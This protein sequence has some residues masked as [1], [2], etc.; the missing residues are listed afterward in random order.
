MQIFY[1]MMIALLAIFKIADAYTD[2][3]PNYFR[4]VITPLVT[5]YKNTPQKQIDWPAYEHLVQY[6]SSQHP[7]A[8]IA[9]S[10]VG[11]WDNISLGEK[12]KL[13]QTTVD[14]VQGSIPIYV[15]L[16]GRYDIKQIISLV[17]F[18]D[19]LDVSGYVITIP[20][21]VKTE[22]QIIDY[23]HKICT[24]ISSN[25]IVLD[26]DEKINANILNKLLSNYPNIKG[27]K[28]DQSDVA[29]YKKMTKAAA[30]RCAIFAGPEK[31]IKNALFNDAVGIIS[32]GAQIYLSSLKKLE[33]A[34]YAND[35]KK[36]SQYQA[37]V[38]QQWN[39]INSSGH[40]GPSIKKELN[41]NCGVHM[42]PRDRGNP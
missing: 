20:C 19:Y 23:F 42:N 4:G 9:V 6:T 33:A 28:Y 32:P 21:F 36:A 24:N 16:G 34:C 2:N 1:A 41:D 37:D 3:Y 18:S 25:I 12:Q 29:Y 39:K 35:K 7:S 13:I 10:E 8:I 14:I 22:K 38:T 40:L 11:Q 31:Q 27:L 26:D 17:K 30:G 5:P 15:G